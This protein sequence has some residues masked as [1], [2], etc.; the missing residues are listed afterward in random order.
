MSY[1]KIIIM[2]I[3]SN[4]APGA[5]HP[6]P[7]GPWRQPRGFTLFN[8]FDLLYRTIKIIILLETLLFN[9]LSRAAAIFVVRAE[10]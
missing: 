1:F 3:I 2:I 7:G 6:R 5:E 9:N 8:S 10:E 4:I